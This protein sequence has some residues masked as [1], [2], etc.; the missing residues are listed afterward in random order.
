MI[1]GGLEGLNSTFFVRFGRGPLFVETS[2]CVRVVY[3]LIVIFFIFLRK[4]MCSGL[5]Q[6]ELSLDLN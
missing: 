1:I 6:F 4:R 2:F 3:A 5:W